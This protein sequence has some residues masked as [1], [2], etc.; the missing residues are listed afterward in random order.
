MKRI[1]CTGPYSRGLYVR[2]ISISCS[3][4]LLSLGHPCSFRSS[5]T[6]FFFSAVGKVSAA[7]SK[8]LPVK[9]VAEARITLGR[10]LYF[11]PVTVHSD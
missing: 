2:I 8:L 10:F 7:G 9:S 4:H 3:I 6:S 11:S 1:R 5:S